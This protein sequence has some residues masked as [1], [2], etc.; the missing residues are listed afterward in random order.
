MKLKKALSYLKLEPRAVTHTRN[1]F[2]G[3]HTFQKNKAFA[4]SLQDANFI[5]YGMAPADIFVDA[6][7]NDHDVFTVDLLNTVQE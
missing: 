6:V 7:D 4:R 5:P 1:N 3:K 2:W